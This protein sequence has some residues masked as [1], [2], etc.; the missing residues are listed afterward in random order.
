MIF[1]NVGKLLPG[2]P[3]LHQS[4]QSSHKNSEPKDE[5]NKN[6][7]ETYNLRKY[8][9]IFSLKTDLGL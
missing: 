2:F 9:S 7:K 1:R 4:S 5:A 8:F 3:T 6:S